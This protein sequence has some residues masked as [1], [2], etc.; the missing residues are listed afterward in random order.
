MN[1]RKIFQHIRDALTSPL[2]IGALEVSTTAIKYLLIRGNTIVQASLRLPPGTIEKGVIK[3]RPV[4]VAAL[5][6]VHSQIGKREQSINVIMVVPSTLI[7]AQSFNVPIVASDDLAEAIRLNLQ[8]V[9]PNKIEESY[10]DYQEIKVN[11]DL[12]HIDLL[13]AFAAMGPMD[14]YEKALREAAFIPVA[15]EFPGLSLARL[16]RERWGGIELEQQYLLM[17]VSGDGVLMMIIKN[18]NLSFNHFTPWQEIGAEHTESL[19]FPQVQALIK[20]EMQRVMNFHL[21]RTGKS[22]EEAVLIS[23]VFNYEIVKM[24]S[25]DLKIKIRNLTIAEL[26]KLQPG[27]FPALGA[28]L[29]G[30]LSRSKDSDVSLAAAN[31]Q[32]EYYHER[33]YN[34]IGLWRNIVIG[35]LIVI[36]AAFTMV[37]TIFRREQLQ[38]QTSLASTFDA[39]TLKASA[40]VVEKINTFNESLA[41]IETTTKK[42]VRWSPTLAL[43]VK[44]AGTDIALERVF[45]GKGDLHGLLNGRGATD[46]AILAFKDRLLKQE[47]VASVDLP[48]SNI[49]IE[50]DKSA[51]FS[52][53]IVFKK[54]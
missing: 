36:L 43:L 37:D 22:L 49:K 50:S 5:Q 7:F 14:E 45:I 1:P 32:T 28:A 33:V 10:Y 9:S 47:S 34:F 12:G 8:M 23:P 41:T 19:T 24:A 40:M 54:L 53:S 30:L 51:S 52:M 48:L 38:L 6:N 29:R 46:E 17:Y 25:E 42:E 2:R 11:K 39:N 3:N 31:S 35:S 13:G 15:T 21:S 16:I 18:G 26:P 44:T 4:F 20:R 27:W